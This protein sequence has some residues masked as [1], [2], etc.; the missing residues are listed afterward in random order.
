MKIPVYDDKEPPYVFIKKLEEYTASLMKE[1]FKQILLFVNKLAKDNKTY[2][3]LGDFK[4]V[5]KTFFSDN[6]HNEKILKTIG[7]NVIKILNIKFDLENIN[8]NSI[9]EF[10]ELIINEIKYSLIKKTINNNT[11]YTIITKQIKKS[12]EEC[13]L[14][15]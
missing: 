13:V 6:V 2:K 9:Y 1:K 12:R 4:N 8:N 11:Y 10:L 14:M 3:A 5:S 7:P 15:K